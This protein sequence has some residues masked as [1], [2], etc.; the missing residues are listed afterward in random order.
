MFR[1]G[2]VSEA[3]VLGS[4]TERITF[5]HPHHVYLAPALY[6]GLP[7]LTLLLGLI[8]GDAVWLVLLVF[9]S[10]CMLTD[11]EQVLNAPR[12]MGFYFGCRSAC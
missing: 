6:G 1:R 7:A 8:G 3:Q 4:A 9:A 11:G 2:A 12:A 5:P 10:P